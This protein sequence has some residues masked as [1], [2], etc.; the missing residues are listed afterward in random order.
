MIVVVVWRALRPKG[1]TPGLVVLLPGELNP[2]YG[3]AIRE[4][5]RR[6]LSEPN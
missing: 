1:E 3:E 5:K 2:A 6:E 4:L